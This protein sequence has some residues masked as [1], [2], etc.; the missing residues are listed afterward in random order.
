MT[1]AKDEVKVVELYVPDTF[2]PRKY[3]WYSFLL[4]AKSNLG[5]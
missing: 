1:M 2:I 3:T 5:P 4:E